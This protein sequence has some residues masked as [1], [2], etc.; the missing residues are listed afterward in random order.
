MSYV[1][2]SVGESGSRGTLQMAEIRYSGGLYGENISQNPAK[3]LEEGFWIELIL[4]RRIQK[5]NLQNTDLY[6]QIMIMIMNS[7]Y[8]ITA[9]IF[10]TSISTTE[11]G[12]WT[13]MLYDTTYVYTTTDISAMITLAWMMLNT[14][15]EHSIALICPFILLS[16][17]LIETQLSLSGSQRLR[18]PTG[19]IPRRGGGR[20]KLCS[21]WAEIS[22]TKKKIIANRGEKIRRPL[23]RDANQE[24]KGRN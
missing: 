6:S 15:K 3:A 4:E 22:D 14:E 18:R 23:T 7:W 11:Y 20:T 17:A 2:S 16:L 8:D 21:I 19:K 24:E 10:N 12:Y 13:H 5:K 9:P 1:F